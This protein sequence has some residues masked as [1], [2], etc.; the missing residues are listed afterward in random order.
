MVNTKSMLMN[1]GYTIDD[2]STFDSSLNYLNKI[3]I[4]SKRTVGSSKCLVVIPGFNDYSFMSSHL[5]LYEKCFKNAI[6]H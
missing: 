1:K 4:V 6:P 5:D 3:R 2:A